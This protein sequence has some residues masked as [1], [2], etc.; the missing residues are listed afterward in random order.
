V[1]ASELTKKKSG[2]LDT[3]LVIQDFWNILI[4]LYVFETIRLEYDRTLL[5]WFWF[6]FQRECHS[7]THQKKSGT[8][9]VSSFIINCK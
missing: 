7:K 5:L 1:D 9:I 2:S 3:V 4:P 6:D 8:T